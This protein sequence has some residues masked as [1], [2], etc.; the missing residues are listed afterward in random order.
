[1]T[2]SI[3]CAPWNKGLARR[4][5]TGRTHFKKGGPAPMR[6]RKRPDITGDNNP[7]KR[8]DVRVKFSGDNNWNWRGGITSENKKQ[9]VLFQ[10]TLQRKVFERDNFTCQE[11]KG[12]GGWLQADHVK[13]W[14]DFPE[15]RFDIN[16]C[17]TLCM[18]CHYFKTFN[19]EIP[20]GLVWGHNL[21]QTGG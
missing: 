18:S 17:R 4:L 2:Y 9:R 14:K 11:C 12:R 20:G 7:A 1:M 5:N 8:P 15:L 21:I 10:R 16:N 3:G 13:S 6:G 19:R